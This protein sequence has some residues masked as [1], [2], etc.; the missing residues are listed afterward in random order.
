MEEGSRRYFIE[1]FGM[2]LRVD[3]A[4]VVLPTIERNFGDRNGGGTSLLDVA[5]AFELVIAN[6]SF[7]K[8][9]EHFVTFKSLVVVTHIDYLL[10]R[11]SD[12]GFCMDLKVIL[13]ENLMTLHR[14][15]VMDLEITRKMK[16][17]PVYSQPMV[18]WGALTE[19]KWNGEVQGKVETKKAAYVKL[20][21][22]I[23]EEERR[24]NK[25]Q[26]KLAKKE[27]KLIVTVAKTAAFSHL[28]EELE[29]HGRDKMLFKLAKIRERKACDLDQVKCIKDEE[30]RVL[31]DE[32]L[33]IKDG[34]PT[35]IVS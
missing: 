32:G 18:K 20:V 12:K 35:S 5:R 13:S 17:R 25:E 6:S 11:K 34:R 30:G 2:E 7:L 33:S 24:V 22:R 4:N 27:A 3:L 29:G 1:W 26:N 10:C 16:K 23:D 8:K 19:T 28:Y 21:E 9:V 14:L 31:L 15:L